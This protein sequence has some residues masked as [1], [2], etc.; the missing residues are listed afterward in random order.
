MTRLKEKG[1]IDEID[2]LV[3]RNPDMTREDAEEY[4]A[5][6]KKSKAVVRTK[7]D[8]EENIFKIG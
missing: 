8:I 5:E 7:G 1:L 2:I 4:L 3:R 6:R